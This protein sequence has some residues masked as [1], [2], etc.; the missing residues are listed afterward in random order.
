MRALEKTDDNATFRSLDLPAEIRNIIYKL[1]FLD[2]ADIHAAHT[3]PPVTLSSKV[4]LA[5]ALPLFYGLV[6]FVLTT[7]NRTD[8]DDWFRNELNLSHNTYSL[9]KMPDNDL[10]RIKN[11]RLTWE[12]VY[13]VPTQLVRIEYLTVDLTH[14]DVMGKALNI[15]STSSWHH[16]QKYKHVEDL[17]RA[18]LNDF[19]Y[20]KEDFAL[21]LEHIK[22]IRA[23]VPRHY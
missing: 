4:L 1:H 21:S 5:E 16:G 2:F 10:S 14:R 11:L 3:Q 17:L 12:E 23:I 9:L 22:S 8:P 7:E 15:S 6:T 20:W 13:R 19:S 18:S